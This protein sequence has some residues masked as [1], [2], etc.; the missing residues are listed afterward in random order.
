M[1]TWRVPRRS[2]LPP[3]APKPR[4]SGPRCGAAR[5]PQRD[6]TRA[7][8]NTR[9]AH[10]Q[11]GGE[12]ASRRHQRRRDVER[13]LSHS[14]WRPPEE[15]QAQRLVGEH[16]ACASR[17]VTLP[18]QAS[19][20]STL[21]VRAGPL[22]RRTHVPSSLSTT[23]SASRSSSYQSMPSSP[24]TSTAV[25][26]LRRHQQHVSSCSYIWRSISTRLAVSVEQVTHVRAVDA[27]RQVA[28]RYAR[29]RAAEGGT[30]WLAVRRLQHSGGARRKRNC[31][32]GGHGSVVSSEE[33]RRKRERLA[34]GGRGR[35]RSLTSLSAARMT[36]MAGTQTRGAGAFLLFTARRRRRF[37]AAA[38]RGTAA[39]KPLARSAA[40]TPPAARRPAA[41]R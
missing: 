26:C 15:R 17:G 29:A 28:Q 14:R 23:H 2:P 20:T 25:S 8:R 6:A 21:L 9:D 5:G 24:R 38:A 32:A 7:R 1:H 18:I 10:A 37:T 19:E 36:C 34:N 39:R 33:T 3:R 30:G 12:P 11:L 31:R 13:R 27:C 22:A 4:R 41:R 16:E 35:Q 40:A